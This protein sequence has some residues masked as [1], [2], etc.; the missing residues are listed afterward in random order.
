MGERLAE[1][2]EVEGQPGVRLTAK[3]LARA[4]R[5]KAER[6]AHHQ[7]MLAALRDLQKLRFGN[8]V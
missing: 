2:C 1:A 4:A 3:G 8:A 7:N 5:D 6:E